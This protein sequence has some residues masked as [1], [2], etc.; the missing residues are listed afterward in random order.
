MNCYLCNAK[1]YFI[2]SWRSLFFNDIEEVACPDCKTGFEKVSGLVC[3]ICGHAGEGIC[4]DC[5]YWETNGYGKSI[6]SG[7]CLYRYNQ[8]MQEYFHQYKFLQDVALAKVFAPEI[9]RLLRKEEGVIM[10]IP[11]NPLKLEE[12]TFSQVNCL[13]D[14]AGIPYRQFLIKSEE[15]QGKKNRLERMA[16]TNLFR[17]NGNAV[18]TKIVLVDDLYTT[19]ATMRQ[20]AKT[21]SE[22]GVEE[23][24]I[25]SLIRG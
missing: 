12:R 13:L 20:A 24:R 15:V 8:P 7:Q 3:G 4:A 25:F 11:M 17:W 16:V 19:G 18:P 23:I 2:P 14:A 9:N 21:L 6:A 10:P 1:L 5:V 22:A